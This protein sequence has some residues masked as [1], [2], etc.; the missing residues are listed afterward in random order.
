MREPCGR[1]T[2][3]TYD[4]AG[5]RQSQTVTTGNDVVVTT[6]HYNSQNRLTSTV[7]ADGDEITTT[8]FR[9]DNNGNMTGKMSSTL[10]QSVGETEYR[11]SVLGVDSNAANTAVYEYN[12]F[13]QLIRTLQG[14]DTVINTFNGEGLRVSKSV[15]GD[16]TRFLY[17]GG[18]VI[19]EVDE[20]GR[21]LARNVHGAGMIISRE[22][23]G[24][25]V[26]YLFNG[27]ADVVALVDTNGAIIARYYYDAFGVILEERYYAEFAN[28]YRYRGYRWDSETGLYYLRHRFYNPVLGRFISA[29]P[30]WGIHNMIFGSNPV[31]IGGV[32]APNQPAIM[33]SL[34]LYVYVLNNP[35]RFTDH[36]GLSIDEEENFNVAD[37]FINYYLSQ[38]AP[39]ASAIFGGAGVIDTSE[40]SQMSD[41]LMV[42]A[43]LLRNIEELDAQGL[44]TGT[45]LN[46]PVFNQ[47][48][49]DTG[50]Q[51]NML[52][53]A[54]SIA[55]IAAFH[56]EEDIGNQTL[57]IAIAIRGEDFNRATSPISTNDPRLAFLGVTQEQTI[58]PRQLT[59]TEIQTV[60]GSGQPFRASFRG[61]EGDVGHVVVGI[62]YAHAPGHG[63]FVV[64]NEPS[65]GRQVVQTFDNFQTLPG[66][67]GWWRTAM[68]WTVIQ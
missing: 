58:E 56:S 23:D 55:M 45:V 4:R 42:F 20:N 29:D 49:I 9:H 16:I 33:Q 30:Y 7:E 57:A 44:V 65:G 24:D 35:I 64:S 25:K 60:I 10:G 61:E 13:N 19:L 51:P 8:V 36:W 62:G 38:I 48:D 59:M 21:E 68:D 39:L 37:F 15:N 11:I 3:F 31:E 12:E 17:D 67:R 52:C 5:N 43:G 66:N 47:Y 18:D 26:F 41:E 50:G 34:N 54:T 2:K 53:W 28:P 63:M 6:Y 40:I 22:V 46:V 14:S 32:V 27:M 1:L